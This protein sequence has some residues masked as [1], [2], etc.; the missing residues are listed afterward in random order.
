MND[1]R[2]TVSIRSEDF[3]TREVE[4]QLTVRFTFHPEVFDRVDD[5]WRAGLYQLHD[6]DEIAEHLLYNLFQGRRVDQLDGWADLPPSAAFVDGIERISVYDMSLAEPVAD[7]QH[8]TI[9]WSLDAW[10]KKYGSHM[11][12]ME[13]R[14][15][16]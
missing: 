8:Q 5:E 1:P 7:Y 14:N 15:G 9:E 2:E 3:V 4:V 13:G 11:G 16:V 6:E 10:R 12:E